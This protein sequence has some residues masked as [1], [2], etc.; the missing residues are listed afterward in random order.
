MSI[1]I[2]VCVGGDDGRSGH[3]GSAAVRPSSLDHHRHHHWCYHHRHHPTLP[4][5]A[6][7]LEGTLPILLLRF[8][9]SCRGFVFGCL[10]L[11][12]QGLS[13]K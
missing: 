13:K 4:H 11:F 2:S 3:S 7:A 8:V 12:L 1:F 5:H 10:C 6:A 9:G